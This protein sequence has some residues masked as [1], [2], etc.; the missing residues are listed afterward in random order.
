MGYTD[1]K[2]IA[3]QLLALYLANPEE[4]LY[5]NIDKK[6]IPKVQAFINKYM[7]NAAKLPNEIMQVYSS[8]ISSYSDYSIIIA[9]H[10]ALLF[11]RKEINVDDIDYSLEIMDDI[12]SKLSSFIVLNQKQ[13]CN[14]YISNS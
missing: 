14:Q 10:R 8:I 1:E 9:S 12:V 6:I 5:F 4:D 3:S 13:S 2:L 11:K 7:N